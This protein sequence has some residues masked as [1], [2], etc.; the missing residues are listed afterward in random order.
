MNVMLKLKKLK[1]TLKTRQMLIGIIRHEHFMDQ[2]VTDY[3]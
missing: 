3:W 2:T 1:K